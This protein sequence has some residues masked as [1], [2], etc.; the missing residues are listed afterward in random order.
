MLALKLEAAAVA[1]VFE[2]VLP[3]RE[4]LEE[5]EPSS[6]MTGELFS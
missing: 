2:Y 4:D 6:N 5:L 1:T 3:L